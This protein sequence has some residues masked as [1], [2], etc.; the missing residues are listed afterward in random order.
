MAKGARRLSLVPQILAGTGTAA[1]AARA[2]PRAEPD[3]IADLCNLFDLE[4]DEIAMFRW[5]ADR[6]GPARV[7]ADG[8]L[9]ARLA[10]QC[11]ELNRAE[12]AL[13]GDVPGGED[14][15]RKRRRSV[16]LLSDSVRKLHRSLG[17]SPLPQ[18]KRDA[19]WDGID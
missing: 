17:L 2:R 19:G 9:L 7:A 18:A 1:A 8:L 4:G 15:R 14:E 6:V 10:K 5:I 11:V 13:R 3:D 16:A 12:A